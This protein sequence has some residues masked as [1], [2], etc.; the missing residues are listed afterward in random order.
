MDSLSW[1]SSITSF[2]H[3]LSGY[4]RNLKTQ[5]L[6]ILLMTSSCSPQ[7]RPF[8]IS[9]TT[10]RYSPPPINRRLEQGTDLSPKRRKF[11]APIVRNSFPLPFP[12]VP[13]I[14]KSCPT[15]ILKPHCESVRYSKSIHIGTWR[16][17]SFMPNQRCS[18]SMAPTER[19]ALSLLV[20]KGAHSQKPPRHSPQQLLIINPRL[21]C[22][23]ELNSLLLPGT[24]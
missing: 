24:R 20:L 9:P 4:Y 10:L 12:C 1:C 6:S 15:S 16:M 23:R 5:T 13:K 18:F 21:G 8:A 7:A 17:E 22:T 19:S 11:L 2:F 14:A 3:G